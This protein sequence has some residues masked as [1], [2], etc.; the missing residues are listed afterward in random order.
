MTC[1]LPLIWCFGT[2]NG[3][4]RIMDL[5][6][7]QI[8]QIEEALTKLQELDAAELPEPAAELAVL[9]GEILEA[10]EQT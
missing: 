4:N 8:T 6:P 5:T 3:D 10:T 2:P 9:L 1:P 7:D